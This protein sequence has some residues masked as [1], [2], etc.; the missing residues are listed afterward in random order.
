MKYKVDAKAV[1]QEIME[2]SRNIEEK[3]RKFKFELEDDIFVSG[4]IVAED[5]DSITI[6]S[7]AMGAPEQKLSRKSIVSR[8]PS[9]VSIMPVALLNTLDKEQIL[10]LLAF[11]LADGN[12][13]SPAFQQ[14]AS[15]K[16]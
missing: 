10:D 11:V 13:D 16:E 9:Q 7:G 1:L 14:D 8:T 3:Y 4:N 5:G 2:P 15:R 12:A 6:Q